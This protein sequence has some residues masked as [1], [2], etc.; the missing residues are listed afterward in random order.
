MTLSL[1]NLSVKSSTPGLLNEVLSESDR[2]G[3]CQSSNRPCCVLIC[4]RGDRGEQP[5]LARAH[6]QQQLRGPDKSRWWSQKVNQSKTFLR[7]GARSPQTLSFAINCEMF[8]Q[9]FSK[10]FML[11]IFNIKPTF[12][13]G[14][15]L[16]KAWL[17]N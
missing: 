10:G 14:I 7:Y 1:H 9:T 11:S 5:G 12:K 17:S 8:G 13:H 2:G 3:M 4:Q 16:Y 6:S 15:E